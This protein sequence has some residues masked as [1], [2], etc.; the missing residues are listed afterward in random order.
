MTAADLLWE[1][2]L[3]GLRRLTWTETDEGWT[4]TTESL[5]LPHLAAGETPLEALDELL[6]FAWRVCR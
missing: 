5:R 6:R 1:A 2:D 4:C 3:L